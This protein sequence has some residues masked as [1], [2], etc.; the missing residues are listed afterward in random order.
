MPI[1]A[2]FLRAVNVGGRRATNDDLVAA[3]TAAGFADVAA[4][5]AAGNLVLDPGDR[6]EDQV[7]V[8]LEVALADALGF[9][10]E[11][12]VRDGA[13]VLAALGSAPWSDDEV[14]TATGKPQVLLLRAAPPAGDAAWV[15]AQATDADPLQLVG[16]DLH[17]LPTA[18]T[19]RAA[20]DVGAIATRLHP[21]TARTLGTLERL[22]ARFLA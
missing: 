1:V 2:C 18:G 17:W 16:R 8:D 15:A 9:S 21:A 14:A 5:Q 20:L 10:T 13:G 6:S 11:V 7:A 19:A 12:V 22:H 4:Y 3:A